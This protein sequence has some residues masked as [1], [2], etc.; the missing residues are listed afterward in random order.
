MGFAN[1]ETE[2]GTLW[3]VLRLLGRPGFAARSLL[4]GRFGDAAENIGQ[5]F[6][7]IPTGGFI[8]RRLS[9]ANFF[10]DTGDITDRSERPEF[11]DLWQ[12]W[13]GASRGSR[14]F[15]ANL[16]M[17]IF[18]GLLTD[19]LTLVTGPTRSVAAGSLTGV[20]REVAAPLVRSALTPK[21]LAAAE[22]IAAKAMRTPLAGE[23]G[24]LAE[25]T[26]G[27]A[28]SLAER[29]AARL[30]R[31]M[32][33]GDELLEQTRQA[34]KYGD[35]SVAKVARVNPFDTDVR[36]SALRAAENTLLHRRADVGQGF[37]GDTFQALN[38]RTA[39]DLAAEELF[40][41]GSGSFFR[42]TTPALNAAVQNL[43]QFEDVVGNPVKM[44]QAG[45]EFR[46]AIDAVKQ[47]RQALSTDLDAGIAHLKQA[48]QIGPGTGVRFAGYELPNAWK[49]VG[50]FATAPGWAKMALSSSERTKPVWD[51]VAHVSQQGWDFVK[52]SLFKKSILGGSKIVEG[53]RQSVD[54]L[55][56]KNVAADRQAE[57]LGIELFGAM[58]E[59]S[60]NAFGR[61]LGKFEDEYQQA[62]PIAATS[63]EVARALGQVP[64]PLATPGPRPILPGEANRPWSELVTQHPPASPA[65]FTPKI[66][67]PAE[68]LG[69]FREQ[70]L[71]IPGVTEKT[72]DG[73]IGSMAK[74]QKDL[75][76]RGIWKDLA[77]APPPGWTSNAKKWAEIAQSPFYLPHQIA[78]AFNELLG[79]GF[80]DQALVQGVRDVFTSARTAPDFEAALRDL[81]AQFG[82]NVDGLSTLQDFDIARL[83]RARMFAHNRTL[84]RSDLW[85]KASRLGAVAGDPL[86]EYL[87]AQFSSTSRNA[88]D[89]PLARGVSKILGGGEFVL[90]KD[91]RG[92]AQLLEWAQRPATSRFF[93]RAVKHTQDGRQ[94]VVLKWP[95]LNTLWKPLMTSSGSIGFHVRNGLSAMVMAGMDEE[96]GWS[97]GGRAVKSVFNS[98]LNS[99]IVRRL[100]GKG[101]APDEISHVVGLL[102]HE[103]AERAASLAFLEASG[104]TYGNRT[105]REIADILDGAIPDKV[106]MADLDRQM[107][108]IDAFGREIRDSWRQ[109]VLE[110]GRAPRLRKAFQKVVQVGQDAANAIESRFRA[111]AMLELLDKGV[112]PTAALARVNRAFVDYS[113]NST[114][115]RFLRDVIPFF[116]FQLGSTA[117]LKTIANRP[118]LVGWMGSA[119]RSAQASVEDMGGSLPQA[120]TESLAL[121]LPWRTPEGNLSVLT[122][123]GLPQ[124]VA[125]QML[126]EVTPT[127]FRKQVLGGLNPVL[128]LPMEAI[129]NRSFFFGDEFAQF[130][131]A[132]PWM[133]D[134]FTQQID[135]PGGGQRREISGVLNEVINALPTS[136]L[137]GQVNRM[138]DPSTP[139]GTAMLH[140]LTGSRTLEVD[141]RRELANRLADFLKEKARTGEV[142]ETMIY[143]ART[144]EGQPIP[145][146]IKEAL[147]GWQG[148]RQ[149][150]RRRGLAH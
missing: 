132:P 17:D 95:G 34:G 135:L 18:G 54:A 64:T 56:A 93:E 80:K 120:A 59:E 101:L 73:W 62:L 20:G 15:W 35:S 149:E 21:G 111:S 65:P 41:R 106:N 131:K 129:A 43:R 6:L 48:G 90:N 44:A 109:A 47:A 142:G 96:I 104:K 134:A 145:A 5:M 58:P 12:R 27:Q 112:E 130:R 31:S 72:I 117:W 49:H 116:R 148:L 99:G 110:P 113:V 140:A 85:A 10:S 13:G 81:G 2:N 50:N 92:N 150:R 114:T 55:S 61:L 144:G 45:P 100:S 136:R 7:D 79:E 105:W 119:Q 127:G 60:R 124:E 16:G 25:K 76:D 108:N 98:M 107:S 137:E 97:A 66:P 125:L 102:S 139:W 28:K 42:E 121:P 74:I 89:F 23:I 94:E 115:E 39:G 147:E 70:A 36:P 52:G 84:L 29:A 77:K 122:S 46:Q 82:V 68:F 33:E 69:R 11:T 19:P 30:A 103:P 123:L 9:L 71:Q 118:R 138:L 146:E 143:F 141:A 26:S 83:F 4:S 38:P 14:G 22:K 63:D 75:I 91:A 78:P 37:V 57:R 133:P 3:N 67:D 40:Y 53:L 126:G 128:R 32:D 8:D 86:S 88:I 1:E 51:A 24:A 87:A